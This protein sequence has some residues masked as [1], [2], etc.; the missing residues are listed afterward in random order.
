VTCPDEQAYERV[1]CAL[2]ELGVLLEG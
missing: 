2:R 1:K